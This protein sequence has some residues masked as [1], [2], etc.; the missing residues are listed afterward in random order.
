MMDADGSHRRRVTRSGRGEDFDPSWAPDAR[1][2][3]FRTSRGRYQPDATG[4]GLEGIFVI[5][6]ETKR[7][8]EL[9]PRTG[10]L[11]PAWSPDGG[12]D[13]V[14]WLSGSRHPGDTIHVMTSSGKRIRDLGGA[15]GG[16][17]ESTVSSP[18]G[19]RIAYS[20]H[21]GDGNWALWVMDR[22]GTHKRRLTS[23]VPLEPAGSG[24][25]CRRVVTRREPDRLQ[26]W[27]VRR[28]RVVRDQERWLRRLPSYGL[29]GS[30][31]RGRVAQERRDRVCPF[32]PRRDG[33]RV[34]HRRS[35]RGQPA[36]SALVRR[37]GRSTRLGATALT[38]A[39]R[40]A[41]PADCRHFLV[42]SGTVF[43]ALIA[44]DLTRRA[45]VAM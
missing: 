1:A 41:N 9:Q 7:E 33:S 21:D 34:V 23:P 4:I 29:A 6:L 10:G 11:F 26:Q 3:V 14:Q 35:G 20:H 44:I 45:A 13:R 8:R 32:R 2:L 5:D 27:A 37:C 39:P 16:T 12:L 15:R 22:D 31:W 17:Q 42:V 18:D 43:A 40:T 36:L 24:R 38:C 25:L 28:P 30:G 19:R